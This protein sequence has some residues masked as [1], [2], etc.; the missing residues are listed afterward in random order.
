MINWLM[1]A[2]RIYAKGIE[3]T[4]DLVWQDFVNLGIFAIFTLEIFIKSV[5][6]GFY[7]EDKDTE[8]ANISP[9]FLKS[10]F[11]N[12]VLATKSR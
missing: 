7:F 8:K 1:Y 4:T 6:F 11:A 10:N 2:I 9:P 3:A 12:F 5:A